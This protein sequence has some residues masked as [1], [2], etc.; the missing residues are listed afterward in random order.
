MLR[1]WSLVLLGCCSATRP[2]VIV[3]PGSLHASL[4]VSIDSGAWSPL[5][6]AWARLRPPLDTQLQFVR[7]VAL[8]TPPG[9]RIRTTHGW[10]DGAGF[11]NT[12]AIP[13]ADPWT[14]APRW[15]GF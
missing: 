1:A 8:P 13:V 3:I 7:Q 12:S 2:P 6:L 11:G 5:Y 10:W 15:G 4:D 14:Y 9:V